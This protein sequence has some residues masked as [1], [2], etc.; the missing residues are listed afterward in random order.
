[1]LKL[2]NHYRYATEEEINFY[3]Q[4]L[5]PLQ[6]FVLSL[7]SDY[8]FIYLTGGTCLARYYLNHR[9]S[10]DI[11]LFIKIDK[12]DDLNAIEEKST[13]IY[14]KDLESKIQ[15]KYPTEPGFYSEAYSKFYVIL[16]NYKMKIDFVREYN[17]LGDLIK[18][19][20]GHYINNFKDISVGKIAAFEDRAEMKDVIDLY[21]LTGQIPL[22]ELFALA[23]KKRELIPYENLLTIN[24]Q[25]ISGRA[26]VTKE[27][28][29]H[30]LTRFLDELVSATEKQVKK[31]EDLVIIDDVIKSLLWDFPRE[32]RSIDH[33]SIPVL[34]RRLKTL[35]LPQKR[36]LQKTLRQSQTA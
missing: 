23:D 36:A 14:A 3:E 15:R 20:T 18:T 28:A 2:A 19:D 10:E 17:H 34:E 13:S 16:D 1:M 21:Y 31:K 29:V 11:D 12:K 6:D 24:Q 27:L 22:D 25:G 32:R 8:D 35:P 33:F 7:C 4:K 9:L 26:L 5:Y 30:E